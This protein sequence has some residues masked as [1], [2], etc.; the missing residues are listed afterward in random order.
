L[1]GHN[2]LGGGQKCSDPRNIT[3]CNERGE[4]RGKER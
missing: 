3:M 4:K 1:K 2:D